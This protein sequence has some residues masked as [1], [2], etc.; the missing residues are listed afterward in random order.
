MTALHRPT[1]EVV[2]PMSTDPHRYLVTGATG[3]LGGLVATSLLRRGARVRLL[4]RGPGRRAAADAPDVQLIRVDSDDAEALHNA[5]D[6]V[7]A[8][9]LVCGENPDRPRFET[10]F[11][12]AAAA[13]HVRIVKLSAVGA[14]PHA[15]TL[16]RWHHAVEDHLRASGTTWTVLRAN[17]L[18]DNLLRNDSR[19]IA[20]GQWRSTLGSARVSFL[21]GTDLAEIAT[22][23]LTGD[24]TAHAGLVHELTGPQSLTAAEVAAT[25]ADVLGH[26]VAVVDTAPEELAQALRRRG[27][28]EFL[29]DGL[30]ELHT[31][32]R[33]GRAA[34]VTDTVERIL[35]R[36][37][38][39]LAEFL[40]AHRE[41]FTAPDVRP[42]SGASPTPEQPPPHDRR[43]A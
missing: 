12:D 37:A 7:T 31:H 15:P 5:V 22:A 16:L 19:A 3:Y 2:T 41:A 28:P 1:R 32:F 18:M 8:A 11:I 17:S 14:S 43:R 27:A 26:P 30:A 39:T 23:V 34:T 36:P 38:T 10:S 6:E 40:T 29:A 9:F 24:S 25:A 20:A 42:G 33:S 13:R 21:A 35:Q 4:T